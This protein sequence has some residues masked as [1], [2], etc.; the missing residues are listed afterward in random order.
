MLK[1]HILPLDRVVRETPDAV[2]L[3][4]RQ[5]A[6]DRI[7]YLPGQYITLKVELNGQ[8]CYRSYSMSSAPQIDPYLEIT[9]QRAGR[10]SGHIVDRFA[11]G[12]LVEFLRPA[13]RFFIEPATKTRRHVVLFGAGSGITPL[14]SILRSILYHEPQSRVSLVYANR[15]HII[16]RGRLAELAA[17]FGDRV[18][19][20]HYLTRPLPGEDLPYRHGRLQAAHIPA[21]LAD[22]PSDADQP[23]SYYLC[24]P[25]GFMDEVQ[26]GLLTAGVEAAQIWQERFEA[27]EAQQTAQAADSGPSYTVELVIG[28]QRHRVRVPYG[29]TVLSAGLAQG[30]D[31]PYSCKRGV[32][33]TCM[34]QLL[35]GTVAM[36]N[37]ES[38]LDFERARGRVL[39]C[40]AHPL[41]ADV[42][43]EIGRW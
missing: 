30:L 19:V 14:L 3:R 22:L 41:D 34:G 24:G 12:Q 4:F 36:D 11:A 42:R 1:T 43:I 5:P 8:T 29:A 33:S 17:R 39:V 15:S 28:G 7:V 23:R 31:L 20:Q 21:L 9:V 35:G 27:G 6:I 16:F 38:L 40:Q 26:T 13:G 2:S 37:P 18:T 32:C 25:A 10:V